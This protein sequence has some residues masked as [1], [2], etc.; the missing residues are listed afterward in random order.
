MS[1][2]L[3][4]TQRIEAFSDAVIAIIITIMVLDLKLPKESLANGVWNGLIE[5]I[6]PKLIAYLLSF[7]VV[8]IIWVRHHHLLHVAPSATRALLWSTYTCYC[9][10][11][12]FRS[13]L[14]F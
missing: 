12:L 4:P 13:R 14:R 9:G 8:A 6:L 10:C 2:A 11:R 5:P 3:P 7:L 1:K